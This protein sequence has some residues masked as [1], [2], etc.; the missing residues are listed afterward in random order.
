MAKKIFIS[1]TGQHRGKTTTSLLLM[2]LARKR[3]KKVGF[4]KP[5]GPKYENYKGLLVDKDALLLAKKY[6]LEEYI[7]YMSPI[8]VDKGFTQRAIKGEITQ[9]RMIE[10]LQESY[11]VLDKEFDFIII[12]GAGHAGVGSVIGMSNAKAAQVLDAPVVM[13]SGGG[14]GQA[15]DEIMLNHALFEKKGVNIDA[16]WVNKLL[17]EKAQHSMHYLSKSFASKGIRTIKGLEYSPV[18]ANPTLRSISALLDLELKGDQSQLSRIVHNIRMGAASSQRVV[19]LLE[20]DTLLVVPSTR[21]ELLVTLSSL[22]SLPEFKE[23]IAGLIIQCIVPV[24]AITQK[25][26]D[27]SNIPYFRTSMNTVGVFTLLLDHVS[28]I[29]ADDTEKIEWINEQAEKTLLKEDVEFLFDLAR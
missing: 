9:E 12:E 7:E 15:I 24:S 29:V 13:V 25:I 10:V 3:Y 20:Q 6:G 22:Y 1:A 27:S 8:V 2:H 26:V 21:D 23:K 19:D 4:I 11:A 5:V 14:I 17:P 28:K 16:V 18:L